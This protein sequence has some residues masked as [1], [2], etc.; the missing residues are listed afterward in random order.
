MCDDLSA[1]MAELRAKGIEFEGEPS[2]ER[3]GLSVTM[4]L[5]GGLEMQLYQPHHPTAI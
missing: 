1:T 5:P 4:L 2:E 3:W